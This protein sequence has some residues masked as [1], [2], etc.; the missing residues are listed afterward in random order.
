MEGT[1]TLGLM[2]VSHVRR[3]NI[4]AFILSDTEVKNYLEV[5]SPDIDTI[6]AMSFTITFGL[7]SPTLIALYGSS[8][9]SM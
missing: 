4:G 7:S 5:H 9:S 3:M 1:Y 8:V 6:R 2:L